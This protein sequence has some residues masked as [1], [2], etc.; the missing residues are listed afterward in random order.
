M[1]TCCHSASSPSRV[2]DAPRLP[3]TKHLVCQATGTIVDD[4]TF[5]GPETSAI[6]LPS[7]GVLD[8]RVPATVL[9]LEQGCGG[10]VFLQ[11]I[12]TGE[13]I[14]NGDVRVTVDMFLYEGTTETPEDLDGRDQATVLV[15]ANG[16]QSVDLYVSNTDEGGDYANIKLVFANFPA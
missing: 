15:P 9:K 7:E 6:N 5:G 14:D 3:G 16:F 12:A 10:E 13:S 4:E 11:V 2:K 1:K 8:P